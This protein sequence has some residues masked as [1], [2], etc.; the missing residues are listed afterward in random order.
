MKIDANDLNNQIN[1]YEVDLITKAKNENIENVVIYY[2]TKDGKEA[3][4][5]SCKDVTYKRISFENHIL[6]WI[7]N[8]QKEVKNIT[9]LNEAFENYKDIVKK[10]TNKYEGRV[11]PLKNLLLEDENLKLLIKEIQPALTESKIEIQT[12][13]WEELK[14]ELNKHD[15][16]NFEFVNLEFD[17]I[18]INKSVKDYYE[19]S[20]NN[21][22]YGLKH[23]VMK[24]SNIHTLSFFI[25]IDWN[26]YFGFTIAE[27][28][29]RKG[30]A[31]DEQF[32]NLSKNILDMKQFKNK[33]IDKEWWI[34]SKFPKTRLDFY[35]FTSDNIFDLVDE[36]KRKKIISDIRE[37]IVDII[38]TFNQS[39]EKQNA[40]F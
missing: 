39:Q 20:K 15:G 29:K 9:N 25:Q 12:K 5:H 4:Q 10:I 34:C 1:D 21:K 14:E 18:D 23:D 24:I 16:Y 33:N 27:N 30:I 17:G 28:R 31:Q 36:N 35:S 11:M 38:T 32:A 13:F 2:L 19:M 26:I 7:E 37:E 40:S 22:Y 8:C 6:N 3:A